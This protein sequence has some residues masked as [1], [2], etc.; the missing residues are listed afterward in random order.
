MVMNFAQAMSMVWP[1]VQQQLAQLPQERKDALA[2]IETRIIKDFPRLKLEIKGDSL[3]PA[4][5]REM[6]QLFD[7]LC[8][9]LPQVTG[10]FGCQIT[11]FD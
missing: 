3:D 2:K 8:Q 5:H 9:T 6:E 1:M 11:V 7:S 4:V 10:M